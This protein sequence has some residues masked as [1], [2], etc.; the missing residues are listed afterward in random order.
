VNEDA[1]DAFHRGDTDQA[2]NLFIEAQTLRPNDARVTL[3]LAAAYHQGGRY[4]EAVIAV[5]RV[6]ASPDPADRNRAYASIGHHEYAAG[7]LA[8]ALDGFKRALIEDPADDVSRRDYELVLRQIAPPPPENPAPGPSPTPQPGEEPPTPSPSQQ[9][10]PNGT[11]DPNGTTGGQGTPTPG[12]RSDDPQSLERQIA[13][14]DAR[15]A[16]LLDEA[17]ENPTAAEALRI[18][19]LLAERNRLAA[20]R[21]AL[22]GNSDPRDY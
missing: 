14:I 20:Q 6:L 11:P 8:N 13:Q 12:A 16:V 7:R 10:G 1:L 22:T 21:D 15:V 4:D 3:N 2:I 19:Q 18:L 5:R 17:G 9:P